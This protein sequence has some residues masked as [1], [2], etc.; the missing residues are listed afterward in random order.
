MINVYINDTN[1]SG[2]VFELSIAKNI[3]A[4]ASEC[5][6]KAIKENEEAYLQ[7]FDAKCGDT[8]WVRDVEESSTQ[9]LFCGKVSSVGYVPCESVLELTAY[10]ITRTLVQNELY[11]Y[12]YGSADSITRKVCEKVGVKCGY[13]E[14]GRS[15]QIMPSVGFTAMD[16]IKTAYGD[17]YFF[18]ANGEKIEVFKVGCAVVDARDTDILSL[19]SY[20]D[21]DK[22][23]NRATVLNFKG[24]GLYT[25]ESKQSID[26][27]GL[28]Q[29]YERLAGVLGTQGAQAKGALKN[30]IHGAELTLFGD[31][32]IK[33]GMEIMLN[34]TK[35]NLSG[36]FLITDVV[37]KIVGGVHT[38]HIKISEESV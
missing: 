28:R 16:I 32:R 6:V 23:K 21:T 30:K 14:P 38:T 19:A 8:V 20:E 33:S 31:I 27:H 13:V 10:D 7:I 34:H 9:V 22:V 35:Y 29:T 25:A 12:F 2:G 3:L 37:Q 26:T 5:K 17:G 18:E 24:W 4:A 36:K 1:I 15:T 11:G